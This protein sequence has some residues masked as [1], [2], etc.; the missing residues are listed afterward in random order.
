MPDA[1]SLGTV[2]LGA[3]LIVATGVM[4]L[5]IE[6]LIWAGTQVGMKAQ[7]SVAIVV[8]TFVFGMALLLGWIPP[9]LG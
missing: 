6:V 8:V 3:A 5:I 9:P 7:Y 1:I 2:A 4:L